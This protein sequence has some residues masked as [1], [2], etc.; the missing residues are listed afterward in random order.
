MPLF[1]ELEQGFY[2]EFFADPDV[3]KSFAIYL[4]LTTELYE[5]GEVIPPFT[6]EHQQSNAIHIT[7]ILWSGPVYRHE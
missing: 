5:L 7:F 4:T 3:I 1:E 2:P 6:A